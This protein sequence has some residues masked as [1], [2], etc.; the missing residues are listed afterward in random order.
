[1]AINF[2]RIRA[3]HQAMM[4][5]LQNLATTHSAGFELVTTELA[6]LEERVKELENE[7]A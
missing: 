1:M 4:M 7:R 6:Q 5:V 2:S 3:N